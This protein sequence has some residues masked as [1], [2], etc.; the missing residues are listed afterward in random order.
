MTATDSHLDGAVKVNSPG[1]GSRPVPALSRMDAIL[2]IVGIVVG[3]GIFKTPS[4]VASI[5]GSAPLTLL[6]WLVG[7]AVSLVLLVPVLGPLAYHFGAVGGTLLFLE[8][9]GK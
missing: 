3:A 2:V 7:G 1:D 6:L 4:L 5:A 8:L 9:E